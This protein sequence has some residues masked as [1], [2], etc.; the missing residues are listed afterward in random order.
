[1]GMQAPPPAH[2]GQ[3]VAARELRTHFY[4]TLPLCFRWRERAD[5]RMLAN[6]PQTDSRRAGG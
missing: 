2:P 3:R 4:F 5:E 6:P 1:M